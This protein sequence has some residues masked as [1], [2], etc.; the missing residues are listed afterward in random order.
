MNRKT[1]NIIVLGCIYGIIFSFVYMSPLGMD[2]YMYAIQQ[3]TVLEAFRMELQ[4]YF[5][6][7]G[8][9]IAH[10][11]LRLLLLMPR[12]LTF[13]FMPSVFIAIFLYAFAMIHGP[14]WREK[15]TVYQILLLFSAFWFLIPKFGSVFFY[16][17]SF[18]NYALMLLLSLIFLY[19]YR[20][21]WV[22]EPTT[23]R[24]RFIAALGM[25]GLGILAGWTNENTGLMVICF[26][27]ITIGYMR[28]QKRIPPLWTYWGAVASVIG[29]LFLILAPGNYIRMAN[30]DFLH[31]TAGSVGYKLYIFFSR[32]IHVNQILIFLLVLLVLILWWKKREW[33]DIK[34]LYVQNSLLFL[35]VAAIGAFSLAGAPFQP[36]RV[37]LSVTVFLLIAICSVVFYRFPHIQKIALLVSGVTCISVGY[38]LFLFVENYQV[39]KERMNVLEGAHGQKDVVWPPFT[40]SNTYFFIGNDSDDMKED[41]AYFIN[42]VASKYYHV[43]SIRIETKKNEP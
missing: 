26:S 2:D 21:L 24:H 12:A 11:S 8:R 41:P 36:N 23:S 6:W 30:P 3:N 25:F 34:K 7:T 14:G 27:I 42:A 9:S 35:F 43:R 29:F 20:T 18:A 10:I 5:S 19:P 1:Q 37:L 31:W 39:Q 40:H 33:L 28:Y 13:F 17:A 32:N 22:N 15:T 4:Q 38:H 16:I